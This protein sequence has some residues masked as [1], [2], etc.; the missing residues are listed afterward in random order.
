MCTENYKTFLREIK[1]Q[2]K[3][4]DTLYPW[5]KRLNFVKML[6]SS[7]SN[8]SFKVSPIIVSAGFF[9]VGMTS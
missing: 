8:Y 9:F 2:N 3:L 4:K 7:K 6:F 1:D 5:M